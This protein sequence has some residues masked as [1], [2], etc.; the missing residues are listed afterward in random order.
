[1]SEFV[2]AMFWASGFVLFNLV[3]MVSLILAAVYIYKI[4]D[5][6]GDSLSKLFGGFTRRKRQ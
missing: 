3:P 1:M 6:A 4:G 2:D 5:A